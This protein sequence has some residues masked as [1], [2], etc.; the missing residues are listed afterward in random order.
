MERR[1]EVHERKRKRRKVSFSTQ[2]KEKKKE[3]KRREGKERKEEG[4]EGERDM[5]LLVHSQHGSK[6]MLLPRLISDTYAN[7]SPREC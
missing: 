1:G 4:R 6:P 2:K 5:P 3:N 7:A